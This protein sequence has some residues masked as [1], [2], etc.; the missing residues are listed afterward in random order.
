MDHCGYNYRS[1]SQL[2]AASVL[3]SPQNVV[4]MGAGFVEGLGQGENTKA[5]VIRLGFMEIIEFCRRFFPGSLYSLE[6]L[7]DTIQVE[8]FSIVFYK[9]S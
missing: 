2:M 4:A 8:V 9:L 3:L 5:A 6:I 1:L 7:V